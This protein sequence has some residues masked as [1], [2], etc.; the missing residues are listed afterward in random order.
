MALTEESLYRGFLLTR[1]RGLGLGAFPALLLAALCFG[2][3]H[4]YQGA[5]GIGSSVMMG[6]LLGSVYLWRKNLTAPIILHAL[7]NLLAYGV[8]P[9]RSS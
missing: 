4:A 6:F 3:Q 2:P 7:W 9:G 5:L 1:L 8:I